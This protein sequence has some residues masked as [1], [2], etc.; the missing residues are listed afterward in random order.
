MTDRLEEA[1]AKVIAKIA[2]EALINARNQLYLDSGMLWAKGATFPPW[3][4]PERA[5]EICEA[6]MWEIERR[7]K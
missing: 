4:R 2:I 6:A 5:A 1:R 3:C 7:L